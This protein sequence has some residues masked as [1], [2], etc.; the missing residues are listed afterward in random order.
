MN[1]GTNGIASQFA[2]ELHKVETEV[3]GEIRK[4]EEK[5]EAFFGQ[6]P[7]LTPVPEAILPNP[8]GASTEPAL[9]F[10]TNPF[11]ATP[12]P[13]TAETPVA[14]TGVTIL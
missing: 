11:S 3:V 10:P 8:I 7:L 4:I 2:A 6:E 12:A 13:A 1:L 9:M 5:V 14:P